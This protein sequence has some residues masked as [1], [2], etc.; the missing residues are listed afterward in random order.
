MSESAMIGTRA[1]L[2]HVVERGAGPPVVLLHATLH[3]RHDFDPITDRLAAHFR[4][5]AIDWPGHGLSDPARPSVTLLADV[6]EDVVDSLGL[7]TAAYIGNSVGAF[8][9]GRLAVRRPEAVTHLILVN[10]G[11]FVTVPW[12]VRAVSRTIGK[13]AIA[14][15]V[16]PRMVPAYMRSRTE[17]DRKIESRA[18]ARAKTPEGA[19]VVASIWRGFSSPDYNLG[20][21]EITAPTLVVWGRHDPIVRRDFLP[22]ALGS[23]V[24]L[25]TGHVAFSSDPDGFLAAA[26]P[27]LG[28]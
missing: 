9:A 1:G 3:D 24:E 26:L 10:P 4:V 19:Q 17:S 22:E 21:S 8:A 11:G 13:P 18:V 28:A 16:M 14:R 25:D 12:F 27:F 5:V 23:I 7:S 20:R 6:L 15:L 2:V